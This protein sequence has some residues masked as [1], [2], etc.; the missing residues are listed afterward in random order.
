[1][2]RVDVP[3]ERAGLIIERGYVSVDVHEAMSLEQIE[4]QLNQGN[5]TEFLV[6]DWEYKDLTYEFGHPLSL[7][8]NDDE[9]N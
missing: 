1:M 6:Q 3:F 8:V 9:A 5:F 7:P 4:E 2:Y